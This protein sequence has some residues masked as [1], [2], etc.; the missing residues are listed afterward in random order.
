MA[1]ESGADM[2][3][4]APAP[5]L[6]R[7]GATVSLKA[8]LLMQGGGKQSITLHRLIVVQ[9]RHQLFALQNPIPLL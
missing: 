4:L 7:P 5:V 8:S 3:P 2:V 1:P 9:Y 6:G